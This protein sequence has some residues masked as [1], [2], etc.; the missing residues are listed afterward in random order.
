M[1]THPVPVRSA[2]ARQTRPGLAL[3]LV[4]AAGALTP[5][6]ITGPSV[7]LPAIG[8]DLGASLVGLQWIVNAYNLTFASAMLAG[9]TVA[10]LLGRRRV[11]TIGLICY[12]AAGALGAVSSHIVVLDV[13]RALAGV[14][15]AFVVTSGSALLADVFRDPAAR[16]RAFSLL[17]ASFGAGLALGPS[18]AGFLVSGFGWQAVFAAHALIAAAV[19]AGVHTLPESRGP[20]GARIDHPGI[21]TFTSSLFLLMLAV[22]EGPQQGWTAP[23]VVGAFAGAAALMAAFVAVERRATRP[24]LDL[25][26]LV[27]GRFVAV[28]A[29]PVVLA[30]GFVCLLVFLPSY[31]I[32]VLG[33][34]PG[35]AGL[36]MMLM[37]VPVVVLPLIAGRLATT[38]PVGL[39]LGVATGLIAAGAAWLTVVAPDIGVL[40]LAGPLL[41]IGSGVGISFGIIDGAAVGTVEPERAGMAAGLFNTVRLGSEAVAVA[42]MGALLVS[43]TRAELADA[44]PDETAASIDMAA[45]QLTQGDMAAAVG[46]VGDLPAAAALLGAAHTA[47]LQTVLWVLAALS[48]VIVPVIVLLLRPRNIVR[49]T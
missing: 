9:G 37:T 48:A 1:S 17:G 13:L 6:G 30:F 46:T 43:I 11:F 27:N 16:A 5:A 35:D 38:L 15:A 32:G 31:F 14:G 33:Q 10:D 12:G 26:L 22:V 49:A 7:A 36:T 28:C 34:S 4:C 45:N 25:S 44:L 41:T 18:T 20:A 23:L 29:V 8:V 40:G 21:A 42:C 47:S 3:L 39:L 2:P 19:L 24:M